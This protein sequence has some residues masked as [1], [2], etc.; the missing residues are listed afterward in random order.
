[1]DRRNAHRGRNAAATLAPQLV[2]RPLQMP[3]R[4]N[5]VPAFKP[6]PKLV[7]GVRGLCGRVLRCRD[8][9]CALTVGCEVAAERNSACQRNYGDEVT[10]KGTLKCRTFKGYGICCKRD[11]MMVNNQCSLNV[12][13]EKVCQRNY[14]NVHDCGGGDSDYDMECKTYKGYGICCYSDEW[15]DNNKCRADCWYNGIKVDC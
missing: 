13:R 14:V 6:C 1:M 12:N 9:F 3:P 4:S 5:P 7:S 2:S 10:C 11:E 8:A 15:M